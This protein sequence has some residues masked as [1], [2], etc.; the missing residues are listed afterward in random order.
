MDRKF[1]KPG[2]QKIKPASTNHT[3]CGVIIKVF[4]DTELSSVVNN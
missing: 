2:F 4:E 1:Y 3:M